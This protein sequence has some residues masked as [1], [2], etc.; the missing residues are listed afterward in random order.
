MKHYSALK[1]KQIFTNTATWMRL[2]D[3][4]VSEINQLKK[5]SMIPLI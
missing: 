1:N 5:D 3:M 2:E 4:M